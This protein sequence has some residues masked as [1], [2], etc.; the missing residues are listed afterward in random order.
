MGYF[1]SP[2]RTFLIGVVAVISTILVAEPAAE[3]SRKRGAQARKGSQPKNPYARELLR[4]KP[5]RQKNRLAALD[6]VGDLTKSHKKKLV[7]AGKTVASGASPAEVLVQY[8][9]FSRRL[10]APRPR[11][12]LVSKSV[13][14]PDREK[15]RLANFLQVVE[16]GGPL[17]EYQSRTLLFSETSRD[18][19][20]RDWRIHHFHL[21]M[22]QMKNDTRFALR[23]KHLALAFV[24]PEK[25]YLLGVLKHEKHVG[26]WQDA[27]LVETLHTEWPKAL[28]AYRMKKKQAAAKSLE[29]RQLRKQGTNAFLTMRDRTDYY[30]PGGGF[31]V[32]GE[33]IEAYELA[34]E[35]LR[36]A[37]KQ[38]GIVELM[39]HQ[40]AYLGVRAM[41]LVDGQQ[42]VLKL[43]G[44]TEG[45]S[46]TVELP[47]ADFSVDGLRTPTLIRRMKKN[48]SRVNSHRFSVSYSPIEGTSIPDPEVKPAG[49]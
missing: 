22:S 35:A 14:I 33:S 49:K 47:G 34:R 2:M 46:D 41:T 18:F 27:S 43:I 6:F 29:W 8:Y 40:P 11:Q 17:L 44:Q 38:Q 25:F 39:Q 37:R 31:T 4:A 48:A 36:A 20:L 16:S 7:D 24:T 30:P 10:I 42:S 28:A 32:E 15:K 26:P 23:T 9:S 19:L 12:L 45:T 5:R 21:G 3:C 1:P 13:V